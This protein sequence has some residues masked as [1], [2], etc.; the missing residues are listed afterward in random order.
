MATYEYKNGN[1]NRIAGGTLF[2]EMAIGTLV[3]FGGSS[4]PTGYLLC[5][6]SA[7]SRTTYA[8]LFAVIGTAFGSGDGSTTFNIPDMREAT[9]KGAGL[10][11]KSNNH[12]DADGLAV[13]EF[14]DDRLQDH[15]HS[16]GAGSYLQTGGSSGVYSSGSSGGTDS[17]GGR[18]YQASSLRTGATTEVKSV[19]VNWIIKAQSVGVPAD[20]VDAIED[21]IGDKLSYST[22]EINTGRK[23]INGKSIYRKVVEAPFTAGVPVN[24]TI[25]GVTLSDFQVI[26]MGH[27]FI[28]SPD[29]GTRQPWGANSNSDV[30]VFY[31]S[32]GTIKFTTTHP[33]GTFY[34]VVEYTKSSS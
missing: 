31:M 4:I 10:T 2:S 15:Y 1:L 17:A 11:S 7:L 9:A 6:G 12:Y 23:W 32:G 16:A 20:F 5:D 28:Y 33:D 25:S 34:A 14:I 3:P 18:I 22:T 30:S 19:G 29:Y 21:V 27:S 13:G 24:V 26:D 8:D